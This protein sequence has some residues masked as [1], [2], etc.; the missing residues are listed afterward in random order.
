MHAVHAI[1][2]ATFTRIYSR[3]RSEVYNALFSCV[4]PS[5][6]VLQTINSF[7]LLYLWIVLEFQ[8]E[9]EH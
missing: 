1:S 5:K 6:L 3:S 2:D 9:Y 4:L 7:S 8:L